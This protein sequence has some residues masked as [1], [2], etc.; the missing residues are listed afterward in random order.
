[1]RVRDQAGVGETSGVCTP[2]HEHLEPTHNAVSCRMKISS[3]S[4]A[5]DFM[6]MHAIILSGVIQV[7]PER[8]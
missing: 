3:A 4:I 5:P 6:Q 8:K 2:V 7:L 1:M